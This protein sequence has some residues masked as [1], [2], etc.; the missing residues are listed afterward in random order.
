MGLREEPSIQR[1]EFR[2]EDTN[3]CHKGLGEENEHPGHVARSLVESWSFGHEEP[4][5]PGLV[6]K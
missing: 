1:S 6:V 4:N 3:R 2:C 5:C